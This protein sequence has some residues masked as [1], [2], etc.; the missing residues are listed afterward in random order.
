MVSCSISLSDEGSIHS[1]ITVLLWPSHKN[2]DQK[3]VGEAEK[4]GRGKSKIESD[5]MMAPPPSPLALTIGPSVP[6]SQPQLPPQES[7]EQKLE[8]FWA[9]KWQEVKE[10]SDSKNHCLPL[11]RIKRIMKAD[12]E[13]RMVSAEAPVV[14]AK[15][16]EMFIMELTMRAW[17]NTEENRRRTL[18]KSDIASAMSKSDMYDFLVD[19]V[20]REDTRPHPVFAGIPGTTIAPTHQHAADPQSGAPTMHMGMPILDQNHPELQTLPSPTPMSPNPEQENN[21][22]PDSD[23]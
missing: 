18:S 13:V 4:E 6:S 8:K 21:H 17:N 23:D 14:F 1:S 12:G 5:P 10:T 20:P 2:M 15:A 19:I 16:C 9:E 22:A 7:L 3:K 11:A